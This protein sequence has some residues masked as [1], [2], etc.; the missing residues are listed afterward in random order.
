[1]IQTSEHRQSVHLDIYIYINIYIK[2]T[3]IIHFGSGHW[4]FVQNIDDDSMY[5]RGFFLRLSHSG[6]DDHILGRL[7]Y[8]DGLA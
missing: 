5:S 4:E 2:Y 7:E 1:M 6:N 3:I 8:I